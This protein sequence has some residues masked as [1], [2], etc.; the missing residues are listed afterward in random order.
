MHIGELLREKGDSVLTVSPNA[1]VTEAAHVL[2]DNKIGL[3]VVLDDH[4][5]VVGVIS[6]RDIVRA[7]ALDCG[8]I[9]EMNVEE[10]MSRDVVT[11][12]QENNPEIVMRLMN[13]HRFRHMPV[14]DHGHLNGVVSSRDLLKYL[15]SEAEMDARSQLLEEIEFL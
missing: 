8:R 7:V 15:L 9:Q 11:C 10:I 14:V 2:F 5:S 1:D 13:K 4:E 12:S 6:E 3:L